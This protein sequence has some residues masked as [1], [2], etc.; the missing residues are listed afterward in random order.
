MRTTIDR[1]GRVVVPKAIRDRM[2]LGDGGE[3]VIIERDGVIE[4]VPAPMDV[5]V[6]DTD[7]GPV[8]S[9]VGDVPPLTD[10][11]VRATIDEVRG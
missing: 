3:V 10:D 6:R 5:V 9:A 8:L 7:D 11:V 1:A 4:I 2:H